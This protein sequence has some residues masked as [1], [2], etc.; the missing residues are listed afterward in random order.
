MAQRHKAREY[1]LQML[2]QWEIGRQQ[3]ERIERGFWQIAG[4]EK[5]RGRSPIHS[6]RAPQKAQPNSTP[7]SRAFQNTGVPNA[8]P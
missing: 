8:S 5:T 6:L 1:A 3:P 7:K 4:A 2:F